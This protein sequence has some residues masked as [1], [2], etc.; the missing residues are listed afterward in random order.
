MSYNVGGMILAYYSP[1]VYRG[2]INVFTFYDISTT[3]HYLLKNGTAVD[4]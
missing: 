4:S 3:Y 2:D 1:R